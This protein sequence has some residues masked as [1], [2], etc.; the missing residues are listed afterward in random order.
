MASNG[1]SLTVIPDAVLRALH[2]VEVSIDFAIES[3]QDTLRGPGNWNL[4]HQAIA[5]CQAL[6]HRSSNR[7]R[8][9]LAVSVTDNV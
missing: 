1:Y 8:L 3:E 9:V 5:R 4:V 2:D 7:I 6:E